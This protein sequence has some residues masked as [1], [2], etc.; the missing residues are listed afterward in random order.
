MPS[1]VTFEIFCNRIASHY[2]NNEIDLSLINED[3]FN[4]YKPMPFICTKHN[5]V[6]YRIPKVICR[7]YSKLICDKCLSEY[8]STNISK[9]IYVKKSEIFSLDKVKDELKNKFINYTI[10]NT[11]DIKYY[12]NNNIYGNSIITLNCPKHGTFSTNIHKIYR[13]IY[14][15]C[16]KCRKE[17]TINKL[18]K[19]GEERRSTFIEDAKKIHGD[20]YDYSLVDI[21]GKSKK[22]KIICPIH[23]VFEM[24]PSNHIHK[25]QGCP[26][27]N[28]IQLNCERRLGEILKQ[29]FNDVEI[30]Y[31]YHGELKRQSLDYYLPKY[32]IG[33]EY[34]GSQH[35]VENSYLIDYRH[36]L[37]HTQMLDKQKYDKCN[38]LG[39]KIFYFTFNK[40]YANIDYLDKIYTN[41]DNLII[42]IKKYIQNISV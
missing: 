19:L 5:Y 13:S 1:K 10:E 18:I 25:G 39:I 24:T 16:D 40:D 14:A 29:N 12:R 32:K 37:D 26:K 33:I 23:G 36:N 22:V 4:Y 15:G 42:D 11:D 27:C 7:N 20:Q 30:I 31:Q 38:E 35:F 21:S 41:I 6:S 34:Q 3:N 9:N 28:R 8:K 17:N 2:T